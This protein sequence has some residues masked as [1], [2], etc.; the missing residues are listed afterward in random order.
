MA[1]IRLQFVLGAGISSRLIAWYGQGYG[2]YSHV[3]AVLPSGELLGARSD[4]V[5]GK[6]AGVQIR[7]QNYER[8]VNRR[9]LTLPC[10]PVTA[11]RWEKRLHSQIGCGYDSADIL[12]FI[13]GKPM[14]QPGNWICSAYQL[15]TMRTVNV[16]PVTELTPQQCPP[17]MLKAMFEAVG[18]V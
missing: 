14:W 1:S 17:N 3:D 7:P 13:L 6:P 4:Q 8:W 5:G 12:G 18:A 10:D 2:G 9:V 11:Y 15:D 16:L